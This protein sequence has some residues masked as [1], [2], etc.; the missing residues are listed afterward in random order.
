MFPLISYH[1][2]QSKLPNLPGSLVLARHEPTVSYQSVYQSSAR[3]AGQ[4]AP[5][6]VTY[7]FVMTLHRIFA[8]IS[9][10]FCP[11]EPILHLTKSYRH[12][13]SS[14]PIGPFQDDGVSLHP[15]L[16]P[17]A[18]STITRATGVEAKSLGR[19]NRLTSACR[20]ACPCFPSQRLTG[21]SSDVNSVII[22]G[23]T[24][25]S[26]KKPP[27]PVPKLLLVPVL[28]ASC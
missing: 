3:L 18:Y 9:N 28:Q 6:S 21:R 27:A 8:S 26:K 1:V 13:N 5:G 7:S 2:S 11:S 16:A 15:T 19:P 12:H 10:H 14:L 17:K 24:T 20:A 4:A 25:H 23:D 22:A